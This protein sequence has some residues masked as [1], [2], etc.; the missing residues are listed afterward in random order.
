MKHLI[1]N[2][3]NKILYYMIIQKINYIIFFILNKI[4]IIFN[5]IYLYQNLRYKIII[6]IL[7]LNKKNSIKI[8]N[9]MR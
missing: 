1:K 3:V 8:L 2:C 5:K 7:I 6:K 4:S 9:F